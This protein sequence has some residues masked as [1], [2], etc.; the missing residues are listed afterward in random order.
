MSTGV[1]A[2]GLAS[3]GDRARS[4]LDA[5][6]RRQT[7]ASVEMGRLAA[8]ILLIT[9]T[10]GLFLT[11]GADARWL[12]ALGRTIAA[13]GAIPAGVPF[14]AG[15]TVHWPNTLVLAELILAGLHAALG[16]RGLALAQ[17]LAVAF[18]LTT[19]ARDARAGGAGASGIAT[20]LAIAALGAFPSL[21]VVRLQLFSLALFPVLVALLRAEARAPSA[22]IWISLPLLALW[23]NL[24]GAALSGLLLLYPYL[25]LGRARRDPRRAA[26]VA[27]LAPVA[28]CLT[29]AGVRTIAY[30]HGLLT[31]VAAEQGVGQWAP[32]GTSPLDC[33]LIAAAVALLARAGLAVGAGR[34][35]PCAGSWELAVV[36]ILAVL[37]VKAARD[38]V[39]LLFFLVAPAARSSRT[40]RDPERHLERSWNGLIPVALAA[41]LPLF[42]LTIARGPQTPGASASMLARAVRLARGRPILADAIP[43]EQVALAGGRIWAGNPLDAFTR[44]TQAQ[45]LAWVDGTG[46]G[47]V[48]LAHRRVA[49]VV[50]SAGS[51]AAATT[52]TDPAFREV[53]ADATAVIFVRRAGG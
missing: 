33:V 11:I 42:V 8:A 50:A 21:T 39:W 22:R 43:A 10:T 14:A 29:P 1:A 4:R 51:A 19:L 46:G 9:A 25:L 18:A 49:V 20:A 27:A 36:L 28:L 17:L 12:A 48:V 34:Y 44:P 40:E 23:S 35:R 6:A 53:A 30:Y 45:Y 52:A 37:T 41:A 13:R 32:L 7:G 38:G 15:A 24:H 2:D 26:A 16:V 3:S 47:A 31:N 5:D